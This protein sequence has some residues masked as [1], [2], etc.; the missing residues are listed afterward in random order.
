MLNHGRDRVQEINAREVSVVEV[1]ANGAWLL[2]TIH[3]VRL[4]NGEGE[5]L[6]ASSLGKTTLYSVALNFVVGR[7]PCFQSIT[8]NVDFGQMG[9]SKS[10]PFCERSQFLA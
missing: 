5:L 8:E 1:Y 10:P 3:L 7:N 6:N 4:M 9:Q 2:V